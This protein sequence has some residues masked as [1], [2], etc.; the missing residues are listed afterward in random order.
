MAWIFGILG[1]VAAVLYWRH[2]V[3][4]DPLLH[5][6]NWSTVGIEGLLYAAAGFVVGWI[7]GFAISKIGHRDL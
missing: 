1:A 3:S 4:I 2:T 6:A 5:P 7:L